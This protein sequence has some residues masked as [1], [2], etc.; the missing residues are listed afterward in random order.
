MARELMDDDESSGSQQEWTESFRDLARVNRYLGGW[1]ALRD[2]VARLPRLPDHFLDVGAG[3][4]DMALRL[5]VYL[6]RRG[7]A[8]R[9]VALDRSAQILSIAAQRLGS[10][11]DVVLVRGDARSLPFAEASFDLAMLNLSLHHFEP[12]DAVIVLRELAR[13][14]TTAVVNDLRR[15]LVAYAFA[16]F[17]FPL[18]THSRLTRNDGPVSVMRSYTPREAHEL[19]RAAGWQ[20][21]EVRTHFGY[22][23]TLCG[24]RA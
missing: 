5:L 8:A 4:C 2:A 11:A 23:M 1:N 14:S 10:A 6:K 13:V 7:I 18:F 16:R 22:R 20:R 24:G 17:A 12:A 19:A 15:S 3:D 21:I 9:G